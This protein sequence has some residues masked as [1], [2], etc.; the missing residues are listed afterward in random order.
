[1][2]FGFMYIFLN[3]Q[4]IHPILM[5]SCTTFLVGCML[6]GLPLPWSCAI[7]G[8]AHFLQSGDVAI[9]C[10]H[11]GN[12]SLTIRWEIVLSLGSVRGSVWGSGGT[13]SNLV[14]GA[15]Q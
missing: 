5:N 14:C 11:S 13:K 1:M 6:V 8:H 7:A 10:C 4:T 15:W 3:L 2:A 9:R 12:S